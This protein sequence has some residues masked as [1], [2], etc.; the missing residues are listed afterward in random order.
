[1]RRLYSSYASSAD[2]FDVSLPFL[3]QQA[4]WLYDRQL[5]QVRAQL[6][7]VNRP[8]SIGTPPTPGSVS[9]SGTAGGHAMTRGGSGGTASNKNKSGFSDTRPGSRVPSS[10]AHRPKERTTSHGDGSK[11]MPRPARGNSYK[12]IGNN[13]HSLM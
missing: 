8:L 13:E 9:A 10:L 2:R 11:E 12:S 6:R 4:A 1:M 7:K 3:T 5:A